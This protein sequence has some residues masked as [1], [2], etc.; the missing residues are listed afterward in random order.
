MLG[1]RLEFEEMIPIQLVK[2][3]PYKLSDSEVEAIDAE[4][5]ELLKKQVIEIT[6]PEYGDYWSNIFSRP[7]KNGKLRM[8]L[9]LSDLNKYLEYYHFKMDT[10]DSAI[11]LISKD[12]YMTSIDLRDAYY[13]IPVA[14]EDR[15]FLKFAWNGQLYQYKVLPNGLSPAPRLFTKLLKPLF[16]KLRSMGHCIIGYIDDSLIV[17]PTKM[18]AEQAVNHAAEMLSGLGFVIHPE[19]SIFEPTQEIEFLGFIINSHNMIVSLSQEKRLDIQN[20][21]K[22][23]L[24]KS[25]PTIRQI[26][27]V[28]GKLVAAFPAVQYAPLHYRG[29]EMNKITALRKHGG[30]F[31]A[32]TTLWSEARNDLNWW[33]TNITLDSTNH[34][35]H[36]P[37]VDIQLDSDASGHGWGGTNGQIEIGG[38]WNAQELSVASENAINYLEILAVYHNLK[39]F[40]KNER[41][42]HVHVRVDNKTA[43]TYINNMGGTKSCTCHTLVVEIWNWCIER[44]IH[45]SASYLPGVENTIADRKS[46][47]F[48]DSTEWMLDP[49]MFQKVCVLLGTPDID[50]FA[51]RL[52]KQLPR[53][54]SWKPDPE[55]EAIDAFSMDW[56]TVYFYAFPPFCLIP[57]CLQKIDSDTAEGIIVVPK[58]PTQPWF[59]KML[60]MLVSDPI[61]LPRGVL[62]Q[63]VSGAEHPLNDKLYLLCCRLS[64]NPSKCRE[65]RTKQCRSYLAHGD[66]R[67]LS[68][69]IAI[70]PDGLN[71]AAAGAEIICRRMLDLC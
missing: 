31:D 15:K 59:A 40:C 10:L 43:M 19:K 69:T 63:P 24:R 6:A 3:H 41:N 42:K 14:Q 62:S 11:K 68:S 52:N 47:Q 30:N 17:S 13:S 4:I 61:L 50:L 22:E 64:G 60:H 33:I 34:P 16:A 58:W 48:D 46:R 45:L 8:I 25:R 36:T 32:K 70:L 65:Y 23:L 51:S 5:M 49:I 7:K 37:K 20:R 66:S 67:Q 53:Y 39:A 57:T 44:N 12:C 2:P 27:T 18:E 29:L 55:A 26:A 38:R 71:F 28:I 9:D 35:I 54:I 1:Y 56:G 21:C